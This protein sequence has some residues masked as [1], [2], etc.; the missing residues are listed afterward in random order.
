[1]LAEACCEQD[2]LMIMT[3][4][5]TGMTEAELFG[6]KWTDFDW[7]TK[8]VLVCR[9]YDNGKFYK[10]KKGKQTRRID[11]DTTL[12]KNLRRW[13]LHSASRFN[14]NVFSAQPDV[15]GH[16]AGLFRDRFRDAAIRANLPSI[17]FEDLRH[18]YV[19]WQISKGKDMFYIQ[20]Q[21]GQ[22]SAQST[23]I[24][25]NGIR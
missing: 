19:H 24:M 15:T 22:D 3:A 5:L 12:V 8:Q 18:T 17:T 25:S 2:H 7:L 23:G 20:S 9:I 21:L 14:A 16:P 13:N 1:M 4:A 10:I 11:L 6:L